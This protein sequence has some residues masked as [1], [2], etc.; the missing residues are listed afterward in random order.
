MKS[1]A[2]TPSKTTSP[3]TDYPHFYKY[4]ERAPSTSFQNLN[5]Y[6][7]GVHTMVE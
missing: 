4:L 3:Y 1:N 2:N 6:K 5:P 7:Y